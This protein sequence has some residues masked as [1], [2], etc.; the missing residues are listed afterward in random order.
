VSIKSIKLTRPQWIEILRIL[1]EEYPPSV[2]VLRARMRAKLGFTSRSHQGLV[3][4]IYVDAVYLDFYSEQK[5][6]MFLLKFGEYLQLE[7][8]RIVI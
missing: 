5:R 7:E 4:G 1:H 3:D 6:T 2:F 8:R